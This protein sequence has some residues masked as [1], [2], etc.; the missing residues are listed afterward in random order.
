MDEALAGLVA[1]GRVTHCLDVGRMRAVWTS[2]QEE[3]N[4]ETTH[5]AVTILL[6]GLMAGLF[7]AGLPAGKE[8]H[9]R[10]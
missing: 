9:T 10:E 1:C 5:R 2:L 6:R 8:G 7:L 4:I 3:V